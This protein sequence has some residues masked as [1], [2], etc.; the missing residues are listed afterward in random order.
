VRLKILSIILG[1]CV[2]ITP[3]LALHNPLETLQKL[4]AVQDQL[5]R[6]DTKALDGQARILGELGA[7]LEHMDEDFFDNARNFYV[8]LLY[9]VHGGNPEHVRHILT[10]TPPEGVDK[11]LIEARVISTL[12]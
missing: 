11:N 1:L 9:L 3:C 12:H 5:A 7:Q 2:S 8:V 10:K 6:G 4:Q